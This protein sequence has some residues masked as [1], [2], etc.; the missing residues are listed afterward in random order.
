MRLEMTNKRVPPPKAARYVL[1]AL[2][3]QGQIHGY[4]SRKLVG[5][6]SYKMDQ[7]GSWAEAVTP[8]PPENAEK[9]NYYRLTD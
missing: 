7:L 6:D 4:P 3:K 2:K 1:R 8:K 5:R 9:A